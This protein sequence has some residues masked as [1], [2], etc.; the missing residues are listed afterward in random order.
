MNANKKIHAFTLTELLVV[1]VISS[2]VITI[3]FLGLNHVQRQVR[4]INQ[5]FEKQ[6]KVIKLERLLNADLNTHKA[7]YDKLRRI[8]FLEN[9]KDTVVYHFLQNQ[10]IRDKDSISLDS[11]NMFLYLD[12]EIVSTGNIDAIEFSFSDTYSQKGFFV[13]KRKDASHYM[14]K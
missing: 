10:I 11:Q 5:T 2:I 1:L 9:Q 7:R 12:G 13:Y 4:L 8:L 6:Q 3:A 14:N